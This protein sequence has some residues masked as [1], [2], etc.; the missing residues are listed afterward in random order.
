MKTRSL[1]TVLFGLLV[2]ALGLGFLLSSLKVIGL[3]ESLG[4]WWPMLIIIVGLLSLM[5]NPRQFL[6]PLLIISAGVVFQISQLGWLGVNAWSVIWP[7]AIIFFGLSVL[8]SHGNPTKDSDELEE[9]KLDL[10]VAFSGQSARSVSKQFTGGRMNALFGGIE[11]DLTEAKLKDGK[12][13]L[14]VMTMFGGIEIRVP[15]TWTVKVSG[16]PLF[17]GWENKTK[18]PKNPAGVL[19]I[20]GTCMFGGVSIKTGPKTD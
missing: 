9:D 16:L 13:D 5:S 19:T 7:L 10:L 14:D 3:G 2:I 4:T 17:G 15:E 18:T 20:H 11:A 1:G 12:A 8:F 6:W